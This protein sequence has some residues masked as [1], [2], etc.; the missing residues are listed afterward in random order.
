MPPR[1]W[2]AKKCRR[3]NRQHHWGNFSCTY[4]KWTS[5]F[6]GLCYCRS[7]VRTGSDL[8]LGINLWFQIALICSLL[9]LGP[10]RKNASIR[11][12][13]LPMRLEGLRMKV[14][15]TIGKCYWE[16]THKRDPE[17]NFQHAAKQAYIALSMAMSAA[18]FEE[19]ER[20]Q[21]KG[22]RQKN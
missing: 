1:L 12:L 3:E 19:V 2:M 11:C 7:K 4:I 15:R 22:F 8:L 21:W 5:T 9:R 16:A 10:I 17:V 18:A 6:W 14:G 13:T 20:H